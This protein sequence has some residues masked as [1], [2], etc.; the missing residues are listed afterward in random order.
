MKANHNGWA[1][2]CNVV[3]VRKSN[4]E[5]TDSDEA[6]VLGELATGNDKRGI[7]KFNAGKAG[8]TFPDYNP[9]TISKCRGCGKKGKFARNFIPNYQ[10]CRGCEIIRKCYQEREKANKD[11]LKKPSAEE[12]HTVYSKPIAQ[13]F[14]NTEYDNVVVHKLKDVHTMDYE[15]VLHAASLYAKDGYYV[16]VMPEIHESETEIRERFGLEGKS[17]AVKI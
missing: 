11:N 9:Y 15:R 2:R 4:H 12:K 7:F 16:Q 14:R 1:C 13:Q 3:Q 6:Q 10:F 5:P 8:Q 17:G